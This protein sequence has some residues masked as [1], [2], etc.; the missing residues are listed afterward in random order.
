VN[1]S[2]WPGLLAL[3]A[4]VLVWSPRAEL[5]AQRLQ[6]LRSLPGPSGAAN[7]R[8]STR[9]RRWMLAGGA[10]MAAG[11]LVG[12]FLGAAVAPAVAVL[13]ERWLRNAGDAVGADDRTAL[14]REL[15]AACDLLGVCLS[16]GVPVSTAL[17]AV[18]AAVPAPLGPHLAGVAAVARLGAEPRRAWADVP[19]Q[20][21]P[22]GRVLVRAGESGAAVAPALRARAADN[23]ASLR[24][25]TEA[26]VR[27]AGIWVLAPLGACFLPA[28]VCLG[29]APL[30]L[31]IAG[32]VLG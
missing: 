12:G 10:G 25:G 30:V 24:A 19:P 3:A 18:S 22:L 14:L 11:L 16:A 4:A 31:G 13:G 21:A 8:I 7:P 26:A 5:T 9:S 15:P 29:V 23:R 1:D 27:R 32:D 17:A 2:G 20:L 28:F 6:S